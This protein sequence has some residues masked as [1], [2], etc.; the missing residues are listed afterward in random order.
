MYKYIQSCTN[1][2]RQLKVVENN[3]ARL[4]QN[5]NNRYDR[6]HDLVVLKF[7]VVYLSSCN[8][9]NASKTHNIRIFDYSHCSHCIKKSKLRLIRNCSKVREALAKKYC[10]Q[11]KQIV[12]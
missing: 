1:F 11:N 2:L 6:L 12:D 7:I 8:K 4:A 3:I 9:R 5:C 10:Y